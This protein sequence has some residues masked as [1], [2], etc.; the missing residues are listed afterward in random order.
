MDE[1]IQ[2]IRRLRQDP[3][4]ER[5]K[6]EQR[7]RMANKVM[8][9]AFAKGYDRRLIVQAVD[10]YDQAIS[11][12]PDLTEPYLKLACLS[13]GFNNTPAAIQLLKTLLAQNPFCEQ[14]EQ[15]CLQYEQELLRSERQ[16]ALS[17]LASRALEGKG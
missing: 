3:G 4:T 9:H 8:E 6:A 7:L 17:Q 15:M 11:L 14:A 12:A 2:G 5:A 13:H 1:P 10:L 16:S